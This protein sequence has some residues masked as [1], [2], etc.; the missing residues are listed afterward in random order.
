MLI[1]TK[2]LISL[3][4]S[5]WNDHVW[6]NWQ[7]PIEDSTLVSICELITLPKVRPYSVKVV[8]MNQKCWCYHNNQSANRMKLLNAVGFKWFFWWK[9]LWFK[10]RLRIVSIS[11]H[12]FHSLIGFFLCQQYLS[13]HWNRLD[14]SAACTAY[15]EQSPMH[16]DMKIF[17]GNCSWNLNKNN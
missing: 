17:E 6:V 1:E 16:S 7:C 14:D 9:F 11:R 13:V 3:N 5:F 8:W 4:N 15:N 2:L 10:V 12:V